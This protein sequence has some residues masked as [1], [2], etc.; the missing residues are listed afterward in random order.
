M[1]IPATPH[2]WVSG[3]YPTTANMDNITDW[4]NFLSN[5]PSCRVYHNTTQSL[6]TGVETPMV[7]N[8]ERYDTDTMHDTATNNGRITIN[9]AGLYVVGLSVGYTANATGTRYTSIRAN[10]G[11]TYLFQDV[12]AAAPTLSTN[13]VIGGVVKLNAGDFILGYA[14]QTSGGALNVLASS[15]TD[16]S[17][18]D[19]WATW[20]GKG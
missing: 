12:R 13:V 1:A 3:E 4:L 19:F 9:T 10:G 16:Y 17:G 2:D 6:T 8:T 5:P 18:A 14:Y 7:F 15:G 20:I 11:T